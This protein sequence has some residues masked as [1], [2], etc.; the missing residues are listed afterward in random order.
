V[1]GGGDQNRIDIPL[2]KEI[3]V[4][5][6]NL[7]RTAEAGSGLFPDVPIDIAQGNDV[8][9]QPGLFGDD[10]ALIPE[11]DCAES[12]SFD[13]MPG[14]FLGPSESRGMGRDHR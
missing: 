13:L 4:I 11:T 2:G 14:F 3:P 9:V 5:L 10:R 8:P 7:G 12:K 1:I 6:V